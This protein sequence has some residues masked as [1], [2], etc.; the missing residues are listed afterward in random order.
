[1]V[2]LIEYFYYSSSYD[3]CYP[4]NGVDC[5]FHGNLGPYPPPCLGLIYK[6]NLFQISNRL[7]TAMQFCKIWSAGRGPPG[8]SAQ[9]WH[10]EM[11]PSVGAPVNAA[12]KP[13]PCMR[14]STAENL[15]RFVHR[16]NGRVRGGPPGRSAQRWPHRADT[17]RGRSGERSLQTWSVHAKIYGGE[18][19]FVLQ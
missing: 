8:R 10:T 2:Q 18:T 7:D 3:H 14:R 9:R 4:I 13:G 12:C 1:M 19:V 15:Q 16:H 6:N 11:T 17:L 5:S